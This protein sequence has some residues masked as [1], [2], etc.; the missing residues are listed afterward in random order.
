MSLETDNIE[1][2]IHV[3]TTSLEIPLSIFSKLTRGDDAH[4]GCFPVTV[5]SASCK[6]GSA[7]E[8]F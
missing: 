7:K 3:A 5:K 6:G 2:R 4:P 1:E 8:M